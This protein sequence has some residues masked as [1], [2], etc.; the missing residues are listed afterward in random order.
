[1][2]GG[3]QYKV[4]HLGM[5][6]LTFAIWENHCPWNSWACSEAAGGGLRV[7]RGRASG[8]PS[9]GLKQ[10]LTLGHGHT[11]RGLLRKGVLTVFNGLETTIG[12]HSEKMHV[13]IHTH[14]YYAGAARSRGHLPRCSAMGSITTKGLGLQQAGERHLDVF[15]WAHEITG[16][17]WVPLGQAD[18]LAWGL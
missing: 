14:T 4:G 17:L 1:M 15:H 7:N 5:L 6:Q 11:T 12:C 8:R 18:G 9:M 2:L 10:C 16:G 3:Y 13:C